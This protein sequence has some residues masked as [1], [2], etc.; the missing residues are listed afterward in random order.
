[1]KL[2]AAPFRS[3]THC[4]IPGLLISAIAFAQNPGWRRADE[5]PP[6]QSADPTTPV[7]RPEPPAPAEQA[8]NVLA[9][10]LTIPS[11]TFVTVRVDQ[12]LSSDHNQPGDFFSATLAQPVVVDGIVVAQRGQVLSGRVSEVERGKRLQNVSRLGVQLTELTLVDGQQVP[13]QTQLVGRKGR[14]TTGQDVGTVAATTAVGAAIG[15]AADWGTGAAIGAGVGVIGGLAGVL[16]SHGAPAVIYPESLLTFRIEAP[17]SFSTD[18]SPQAFRYVDPNQYPETLQ[19]RAAAPPMRPR[20]YAPVAYPYPY[21]GPWAYP[22]PY[23]YY[24]G[25]GIAVVVGRGWYGP[26]WYGP[27][28]YRWRR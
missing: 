17:V 15:A 7:A 16:L 6:V 22:Y 21:P 4:L 20:A 27:G 25:P 2:H 26:R 3:A 28:Y 11:G 13:I 12:P 10:R 8:S 18:R 5:P 14:S 23:P 19:E 24:G 9:S 1:M